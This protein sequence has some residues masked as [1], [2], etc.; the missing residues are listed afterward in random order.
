MALVFQ[1]D[2]QGHTRPKLRCDACGGMIEDSAGG[3]ALWDRQSEPPGSVLE[4]SFHCGGCV[5]KA[6]GAP[7]N[8]MPINLFM[9][10]LANNIHLTPGTLEAAGRSLTVTAA[11]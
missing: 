8:A 1:I 7:A 9:L 3:V 10:Y 4:P 5:A 2:D 6:G 11:R